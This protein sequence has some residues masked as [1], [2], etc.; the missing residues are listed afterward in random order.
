MQIDLHRQLAST[1]N[2]SYST[3]S[4]IDPSEQVD[5]TGADIKMASAHDKSYGKTRKDS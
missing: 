1:G 3:S 2:A 5:I 4:V